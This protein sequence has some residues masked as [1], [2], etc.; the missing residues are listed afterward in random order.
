MI[1]TP[2]N[3]LKS[4]KESESLVWLSSKTKAKTCQLCGKPVQYKVPTEKY[5]YFE[6]RQG[7]GWREYY[8]DQGGS[9]P[10]P[11][12]VIRQLG[13]LFTE[14]QKKIYSCITAILAEDKIMQWQIDILEKINYLCKQCHASKQDIYQVLK[15]ITLY[16]KALGDGEK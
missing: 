7:H 5:I 15:L 2:D 6:C 1:D 4:P 3:H 13:D 8:Q 16:H 12:K 14:E 10:Q 11:A 9:R